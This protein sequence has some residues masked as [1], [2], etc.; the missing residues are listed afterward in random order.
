MASGR[1]TEKFIELVRAVHGDLYDYSKVVYVSS[2]K[3]VTIIC[4]KH[5]E[6]NQL[7]NLHRRGS[8]CPSCATE[9]TTAGKR[10]PLETFI[11]QA[12][13]IHGEKYDYSKVV[14]TRNNN[15]IVIVCPSHG[16]FCQPPHIHLKGAGC[17]ACRAEQLERKR[18][19]KENRA[20]AAPK[21]WQESSRTKPKTFE[22]FLTRA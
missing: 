10:K 7:A 5:G 22:D 1:T 8:I 20:E 2:D 4:K 11:K 9:Q 6:F 21:G 3:H 13:E 16:E 15:P 18:S 19:E 14:Y 17:K 12:Q